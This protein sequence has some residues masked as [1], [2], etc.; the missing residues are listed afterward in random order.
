[1][2]LIECFHEAIFSSV[3]GTL[4][5]FIAEEK[6]MS[7]PGGYSWLTGPPAYGEGGWSPREMKMEK[8]GV[9][10]VNRNIPP[11]QGSCRGSCVHIKCYGSV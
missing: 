7:G 2:G 11:D 8:T 9:P 3:V 6:A 4:C 10:L 1:M 5:P